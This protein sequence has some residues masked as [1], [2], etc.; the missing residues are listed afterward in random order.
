MAVGAWIIWIRT[1]MCAATGPAVTASRRHFLT[2]QMSQLRDI[3]FSVWVKIVTAIAIAQGAITAAHQRWRHTAMQ[4]ALITKSR[5]NVTAIIS[6]Q[7]IRVRPIGPGTRKPKGW[8]IV[9]KTAA[10]PSPAKAL[11]FAKTRRMSRISGCVELFFTNA[12]QRLTTFSL[13]FFEDA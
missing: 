3:I 1:V 9:T 5:G 12:S 10:K 8:M 2:S 11:G 13:E 7:Y 4:A 6:S